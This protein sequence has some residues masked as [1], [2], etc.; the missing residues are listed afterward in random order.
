M[1]LK[2][3]YNPYVSAASILQLLLCERHQF[4][5][6]AELNFSQ[7][8]HCIIIYMYMYLFLLCHDTYFRQYL[9]ILWLGPFW[10]DKF[11]ENNFS[12]KKK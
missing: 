7:E 4:K 6:Q 1:F 12:L 3:R 10:P 2:S 11:S 8:I 9:E 5:Y